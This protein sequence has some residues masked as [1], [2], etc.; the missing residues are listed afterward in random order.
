MLLN[1]GDEPKIYFKPQ[2]ECRVHREHY[3][4]GKDKTIVQVLWYDI[5]AGGN[6]YTSR[7]PSYPLLDITERAQAEGDRHYITPRLLADA[8]VN[9]LR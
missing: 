1:D 4:F 5:Q 3:A 2:L 7:N 9:L 6:V 8:L